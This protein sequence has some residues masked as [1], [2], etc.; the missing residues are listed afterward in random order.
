MQN[1]RVRNLFSTIL[2]AG[3]VA[4]GL[5]L[6][7]C[8]DEF[9][10]QDAIRAQQETLAALEDQDAKNAAAAQ[11]MTDSLDRVGAKN[12]LH[13]NGGCGRTR[14]YYQRTYQRYCLG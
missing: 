11:A 10:E 12:Q 4:G 3:V 5:V 7:S 1:T 2:G 8:E 14:K 9:T 13:R 6:S